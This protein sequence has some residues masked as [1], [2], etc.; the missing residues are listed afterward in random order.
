M[1]KA[2]G[3]KE[4]FTGVVHLPIQELKRRCK[5]SE[6]VFQGVC[7]MNGWYPGKQITEKEY[8]NAIDTFLKMDVG[9]EKC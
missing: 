4:N 5:T 3:N 2:K 8:Q 6:V 1:E 9:G 7:A